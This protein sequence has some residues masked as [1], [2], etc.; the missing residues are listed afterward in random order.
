MIH[1]ARFEA[2]SG[3]RTQSLTHKEAA[4]LKLLVDR[5]GSVVSRDEILNHVWSEDEFPTSRTVDNFIMRL[6]RLVEA[7]PENPQIIKSVRGVGYQLTL[8]AAAPRLKETSA[9]EPF[10]KPQSAA[11]IG[12]GPPFGSCA[13]PAGTIRI[14]RSSKQT[15]TFIDLCKKPAVACE[16]T[17]G[18]IRDFDF[19]AAI[20][21]SDLLFPLEV[22]GMGL[23]YDPGPKLGWH[24]RECADL[25][26]LKGGAKKAAELSYQADAM[27]LIRSALPASK[28][29]LGFVGGPATLFAY[30]VEG[31]HS[32][33]LAS[34]KAGL[35]DGRFEG[36]NEQLLELLAENMAL[37]ARAG[38]DT[39]AVL[40]TC[41]GEF[42]PEIYRQARRAAARGSCSPASRRSAPRP[43][44]PTTPRRLA[45]RT[46]SRSRGCRSPAKASTGTTTS[47]R[48]CAIGAHA[49]RSRA[50]STRTGFSWR[51]RELE[52]R[53]REVF[54]PG[55]GL[56]AEPRAG[57][58]LRA[59]PRRA[60][61]NARKQRPALSPAAT[62][63]VFLKDSMNTTSELLK[64]YNVPGPALHEL[65][66]GPVLG[67]NPDRGAVDR[68][69]RPG[70]RRERPRV[71][72]SGAL[73]AHPVLRVA[74]HL[75]RL[76]YAHHAQPQSR[77]PLCPDSAQ[78]VGPLS[79]AP[80][81][82]GFDL[83]DPPGRGHADVPGAR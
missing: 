63:D 50:T 54:A 22:M 81:P 69:H 5:R 49:G 11:R 40:D 43:R 20:L 2:E 15:H 21:F 66:D 78:G 52:R 68:Q 58:G 18:P 3:G 38:A 19:D 1:F 67:A 77:Q 71:H 53:L 65:P 16:A 47:R 56:P 23:K 4:L 27:R 57:L 26:K 34:T 61:K 70:A 17:M 25:K 24:L 59:G 7:D 55:Q 12:A 29:L 13:R 83:R 60:P 39:V 46:G 75:L 44:S 76:Q 42:D 30:A 10:L 35:T 41:A 9:H 62:R 80:G 73:P 45:L 28:G 64:K 79:F 74:L 37:Q 6:R 82:R 48:R 72:R 31:G 36:F 8:A 14:T 32:G 33:E 51:R